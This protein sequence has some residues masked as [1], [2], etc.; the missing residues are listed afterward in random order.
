VLAIVLLLGVVGATLYG[1]TGRY[2]N[3]KYEIKA[4]S[5]NIPSDAAAVERGKRFANAIGKCTDCHGANLQGHVMIND[6]MF[7]ILAA[8]NLT[9]GKGGVAANYK[10]DADWI[11]S[12]R[13]GVR[14][15]GSALLFMPSQYY[16][17]LS[18]Q[19]LGDIVAYL[20]SLPPQDNEVPARA[21]GPIA[22]ALTAAKKL[23]PLPVEQI[24]HDAPRP[25]DVAPGVTVEY[26]KYMAV[27]GGCEGCHRANLAGGKDA[28]GPPGAPPPSNLTPAGALATWSEQDFFNA[29]RTGKRPDGSNIDPFMPWRFTAQMTDDEIRALWLYI[30]TLPPTPT[31]EK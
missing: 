28:F 11:R 31:P 3:R 8:P 5:V 23:P 2:F 22:R 15:D 19:D 18:D 14:P 4:E 10:T 27:V 9:S 12:L 16:Y 30:K 1:V 7:A 13:H 21:I 20:K 29:L 17:H 26:G 6:P 25:A 24:D